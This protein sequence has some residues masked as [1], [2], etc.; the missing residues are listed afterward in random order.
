MDKPPEK[1]HGNAA[2]SNGEE[3][4]K[5]SGDAIANPG[6]VGVTEKAKES[7]LNQDFQNTMRQSDQRRRR[8]AKRTAFSDSDST[9]DSDSESDGDLSMA[10]MVKLVE[11]KDGLLETKQKEFEELKDKVVRT[12]AE[13]EN[14][15]ART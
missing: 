1:E 8:A 11:E 5:P 14:A 4:A 13:M 10:G 3:P 15:M 2:Q 9:S 7:G 6:E 12:L